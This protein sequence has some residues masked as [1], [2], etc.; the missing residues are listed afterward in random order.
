MLKEK[1]EKKIK[2]QDKKNYMGH[3]KLTCHTHNQNH[4]IRLA[5]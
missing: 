1:F 3:P 5:P 4:E 2:K